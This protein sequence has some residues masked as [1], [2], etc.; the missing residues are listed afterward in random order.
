MLGLVVEFIATMVF[1]MLVVLTGGD[2][3]K[4]GIGLAAMVIFGSA[5]N[6]GHLNPLVSLITFLNRNSGMTFVRLL[7][8]IIMQTG[9]AVVGHF[10]LKLRN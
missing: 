1:S 8:L 6:V 3:V 5:F 9:G 7:S 4:L 2:G 10:L